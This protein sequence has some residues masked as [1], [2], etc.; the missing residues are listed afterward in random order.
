MSSAR[1]SF[2]RISTKKWSGADD[3]L[4][5]LRR[6]YYADI[7]QAETSGQNLR[8]SIGVCTNLPLRFSVCICMVCGNQRL[9]PAMIFFTHV[10]LHKL[11]VHVFH[12][13]IVAGGKILVHGNRRCGSPDSGAP[14][15]Q[16]VDQTCHVTGAETVVD[17]LDRDIAGATVQHAEQCGQALET[18]AVADAGGHGDDGT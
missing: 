14:H 16:P 7:R 2:E 12:V 4:I 8:A 1:S 13:G 5:G 10:P 11:A 18:R 15:L 3:L 9:Q 17:V 6:A